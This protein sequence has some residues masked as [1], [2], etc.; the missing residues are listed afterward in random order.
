MNS[1]VKLQEK[2]FYQGN[3]VKD[4]AQNEKDQLT[5][6][7][8]KLYQIKSPNRWNWD[9]DH[10]KY[11]SSFA[12]ILSICLYNFMNYHNGVSPQNSATVSKSS[13]NNANTVMKL[14]TNI[15]RL[16]N[17]INQNIDKIDVIE[18]YDLIRDRVML[19]RKF[20]FKNNTNLVSKFEKSLKIIT[21]YDAL[22]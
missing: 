16:I 14:S 11:R 12:F 19:L 18:L 5:C 21:I 7:T 6:I 10:A 22:Q 8:N 17:D 1:Y 9:H 3:T 13:K 15:I 4:N 20:A 2:I